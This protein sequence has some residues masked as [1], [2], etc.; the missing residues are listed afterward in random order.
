[1]AADVFQYD[2]LTQ[3]ARDA[4]DALRAFRDAR[5]KL[6]HVRDTMIRYR[7]GDGSLPAHYALLQTKCSVQAGGYADANT[8]T[9]ALF[10][11]LD[12]LVVKVATD[13]ATS[14]VLTAGDQCCAKFGV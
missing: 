5:D 4:A 9:K 7:S 11:E 2:P 1:M 14:N 12:T 8:A 10:D 13:G 6:K 3:P